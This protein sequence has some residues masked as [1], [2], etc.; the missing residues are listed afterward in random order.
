MTET[1]YQ[2]FKELFYEDSKAFFAEADR[3][4]DRERLYLYLYIRMAADLYPAFVEKGISGKVYVD[5]FYDITI[6]YNQCVKK[7]GVP[8]LVE[9]RWLSLALRMKIFRLGRLQFEPE[10]FGPEYTIFDCES[11]LLSPKLQKLLKPD[12]NI[13]KFQN[14][15]QIEKIIYPFRQA[16]ERVFGRVRE[17]KEQYPESTSLQ[18]AVKAMVLTGED[19]GIGYGVIYRK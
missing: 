10:F 13:L 7:K 11:W 12:S 2:S 18:R 15:F 14:R 6:W 16:E 9:E 1:F 8:G 5:T 3:R 4:T 19:V 17:D